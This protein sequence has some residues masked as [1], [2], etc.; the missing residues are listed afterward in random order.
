MFVHI[1]C[2]NFFV[3]C[4]LVSRPELQG[5]P[6]VVAN[7][8]ENHGGIILAL[9]QE[10][11]AVGLKRGNPL[12]QVTKIIERN[13]VTVI[14]VHHNLYH[15]ISG[16]IM[17][18][19]RQS[20]MVLDFVQ[21]SVDEFFG[22]MPDDD[23]TRLRNYLQQL[24][25]LIWQETSIPVSCGAGLTY[26]LAKTATYFAKHYKGYHG[27]CVMPADKRQ[28]ALLQVPAKDI[29]GIGRRSIKA[30]QQRN[31]ET[32]WAFTQLSEQ[33]VKSL[34]GIRGV[35]T[36]SELKGIPALVLTGKSARQQSIMY[37]RTFAQMI[38]SKEALLTQ[39]NN[40]TSAACRRLR[41]Q[42][43]LCTSVS[44]FVATNRHREDLPQYHND[45]TIRLHTATD[46]TIEISSAVKVLL[47]RLFRPGYLYKQAGVILSGLQESDGI[48]LDMFADNYVEES[49]RRKKLMQVFDRINA[50]HGSN[51]LHFSGQGEASGEQMAGFMRPHKIEDDTD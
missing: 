10:A 16:H 22:V 15:E 50:K 6:V 34:F 31:V 7:E 38:G 8:N 39:L 3:S 48:Q 5:T 44:L 4:E 1:D 41:A 28:Q 43:S 37:S 29:W 24:K 11:K 23:P 46:D 14:D 32:A 49:N 2:N 25:E 9:N 36:W 18:V 26:T 33:V 30:L 20:E 17:D 12:F 21:Y 19:V 35:R 40:F 42:K 27:I 47:D 45:Q 51:K 13:H